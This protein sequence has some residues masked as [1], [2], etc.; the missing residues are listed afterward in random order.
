MRER[1][2][3]IIP[4]FPPTPYTNYEESNTCTCHA[5]AVHRVP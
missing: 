2:K 4:N 3:G 1:G 5:H